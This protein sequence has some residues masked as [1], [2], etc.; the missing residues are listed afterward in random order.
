M[1]D[2][3]RN[4]GGARPAVVGLDFFP[5]GLAGLTDLNGHWKSPDFRDSS[6]EIHEYF[7]YGIIRRNL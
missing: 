7:R 1:S 2:Q 4:Q 6:L 5:A 3:W